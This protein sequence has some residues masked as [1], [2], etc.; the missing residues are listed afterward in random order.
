MITWIR[1]RIEHYR[2]ARCYVIYHFGMFDCPGY[3]G[4]RY[5][6]P[7][8]L[9]FTSKTD[10]LWMARKWAKIYHADPSPVVLT[11]QEALDL[12]EIMDL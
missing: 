4:N 11:R 5:P 7:P 9:C 3:C 8:N 2:N 12:Y 1:K 6:P 10:A